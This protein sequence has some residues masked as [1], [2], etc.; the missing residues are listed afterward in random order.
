ME[1]II[2]DFMGNARLKLI[3]KGI[4]IAVA[5]ALEDPSLLLFKDIAISFAEM[6][7]HRP[8]LPTPLKFCGKANAG[9]NQICGDI[10]RR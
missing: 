5:R 4:G 1:N 2:P 6:T 3:S 8:N 9:D 7:W 10:L